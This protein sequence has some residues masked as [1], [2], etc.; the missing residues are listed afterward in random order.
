MNM[1]TALIDQRSSKKVRMDIPD[2]MDRIQILT[3]IK[4]PKWRNAQN[5]KRGVTLISKKGEI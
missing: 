3:P 4:L 1:E 2:G 5:G